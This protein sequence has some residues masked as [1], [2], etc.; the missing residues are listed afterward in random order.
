MCPLARWEGMPPSVQV[1]PLGGALSCLCVCVCVYPNME[2]GP[3]PAVCVVL[4]LYSNE[5]VTICFTVHIE[6]LYLEILFVCV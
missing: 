4:L 3:E 5:C 2:W 6:I 1:L